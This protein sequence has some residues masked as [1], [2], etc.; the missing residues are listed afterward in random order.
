MAANFEKELCAR[1]FLDTAGSM[2]RVRIVVGLF[3]KYDVSCIDDFDGLNVAQ[4]LAQISGAED[5][6]LTNCEVAFLERVAVQACRRGK[7]RRANPSAGRHVVSKASKPDGNVMSN[8]VHV[9]KR[10]Q[11]DVIDVRD[12]FPAKVTKRLASQLPTAADRV[13]WMA[14]AR[15]AAIA[16]CCPKSH[17]SVFSGLRCWVA[18]AQEMLGCTGNEFPPSVDGLLAWSCTFRN[19]GTFAN[20]LNHVR[21]GCEILGVSTEVFSCRVVKRAGIAIDKRRQFVP[22]KRLFIV[23][24][25]VRKLVKLAVDLGQEPE[26][27]LYLASYVFLLRVPSEGLPMVAGG[28]GVDPGEHSVISVE[29]DC[30]ILNLASRKNK[31]LGSVLKRQCW[32]KSCKLT[33]PVHVLGAF[34]KKLP[35]GTK[36]FDGFTLTSLLCTLRQ[37]LATLGVNDASLYRTHDF[38]RGH[39]KDLQDSGAPLYAIL[40]A[41]EWRSG[42]F[43]SYLDLHKM[44]A[45]MVL[46]AHYNNSSD[47]EGDM[48]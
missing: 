40:K 46:Q 2:E 10:S 36:L 45:D 38:R 31:P 18:F 21:F 19:K 11:V 9:V 15:I 33:C 35:A 32:C 3:A 20:Y 34:V 28:V 1:G 17:E 6:K 26:A 30:I 47:E 27:M 39:A 13:A 8:I 22:R 7:A 41:G 25:L 5:T 12:E 16:G 44:E 37:R 48:Q 42:S 23:L 4:F 14:N 29:S 43:L 24:A